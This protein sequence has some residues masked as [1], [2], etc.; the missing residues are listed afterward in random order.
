[1]TSKHVSIGLGIGAVGATLVAIL[2]GA[3]QASRTAGDFHVTSSADGRSAYLWAVD[4]NSI[5]FVGSAAA[6]K[7]KQADHEADDADEGGKNKGKGEQEKPE[8]EDDST[9]A[10][11]K[12]KGKGKGK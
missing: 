6:P 3:G 7:G 9:G 5:R 1:M 2:A 10:P 8:T 11:G 4:G 12:G